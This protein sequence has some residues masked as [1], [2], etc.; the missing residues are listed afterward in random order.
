M[1]DVTHR[2]RTSQF[3]YPMLLMSFALWL[4]T[5]CS[6]GG[7]NPGQSSSA[8]PSQP[9]FNSL[10][11]LGEALFFDVNLSLNRTQSCATCHDP[12]TA[13]IDS[14]LDSAG[15]TSAFSLG[16]DG[17]SL[18]DRNT[19]TAAY[20]SFSPLFQWASHPRYN[21]QQPNYIGYVGGLFLDGRAEDLVQQ[22]G[23][24]PLN[25]IEMGMPDTQAVVE[26]IRENPTYSDAFNRL[27]GTDIFTDSDAAYNAMTQAIAAFE[28]T[29]E[30][31]PFDSKYD[32][33][34]RGEYR[35]DPLS[36]SGQGKALF[37]SQQFTNCATCH[38]LKPNGSKG[39]TFSKYEYHNIGV[40]PNL[41]G[42][43]LAGKTGDF[44]DAG[45]QGHPELN[46][47]AE[48]R[49]KH[50]VPTLRNV[51]VTGPY[52]HNGVFRKLRTVLE[53]Y[54]HFLEG[55]LHTINP[56]TGAPWDDPEVAENISDP[57]MR[58]GRKLSDEEIDALECF[59][60]TLTDARYEPLLNAADADCNE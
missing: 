16:D 17:L 26:R 29:V 43:L 14:R 12:E 18:G 31:N 35:Y 25:P 41:A 57:E 19:P 37:F 33:S 11:A 46:N 44:V 55:S 47:E 48:L 6:N 38:Q 45:L 40:P 13:F 7:N 30:F 60:Q 21:S 42:R 39:E 52:M 56:E 27:F 51:A 8:T 32:R 9:A 20:A 36:K 4:L 1:Y 28:R 59:L 49:G 34:L 15:N 22:A 58:D 10:E 2:Y 5:S 23:G 54:D 3:S 24:P 50:K 53:F